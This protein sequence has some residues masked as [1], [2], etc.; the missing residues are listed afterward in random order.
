MVVDSP[1]EP[2]RE[3]ADSEDEDDH[4]KADPSSVVEATD[5]STS[6]K[7]GAADQAVTDPE[8]PATTG[9]TSESLGS[10]SGESQEP[11]PGNHVEEGSSVTETPIVG[12]AEGGEEA[13]GPE[14][15]DEQLAKADE[16][17]NNA[18]E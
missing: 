2:P 13:R 8:T 14:E 4:D 6:D 11:T 3:F 18:A 16:E 5:G 17:N 15:Q 7:A 12:D 9:D 1:D 10:T